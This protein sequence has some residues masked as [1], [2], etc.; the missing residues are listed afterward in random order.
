[1]HATQGK[2]YK[3]DDR[4]GNRGFSGHPATT[5]N[6]LNVKDTKITGLGGG[7]MGAASKKSGASSQLMH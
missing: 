1:M 4:F 5:K 3:P 7:F 2:F 6:S